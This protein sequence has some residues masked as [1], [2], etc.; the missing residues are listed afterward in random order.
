VALL[1]D[2]AGGVSGGAAAAQRFIEYFS[3]DS[4]F[5]PDNLCSHFSRVNALIQGDQNA[6]DT[7]GIAVVVD[8]TR[9]FGA[10][11]GD[12]EAWFFP[13]DG[14]FVDLTSG[15]V[16][17]P[18]LGSGSATT[19]PFSM[20]VRS[21]ILLLCSDGLHKYADFVKIRERLE[22]Q[23][24]QKLPA[25]LADLARMPSGGLQDDLSIVAVLIE[26]L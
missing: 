2:G 13:T 7:T 6:G 24:F 26:D 10:S 1:A 23:N 18:L 22:E 11:V 14:E 17:K 8:K 12:S 21:G 19:I 5:A 25:D 20:E 9:L 15:Q 3:T 16:R 4:D